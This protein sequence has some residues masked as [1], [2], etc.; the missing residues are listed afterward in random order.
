MLQLQLHAEVVVLLS[1]LLPANVV[2]ANFCEI[3]LAVNLFLALLQ[4]P[5]I[6]FKARFLLWQ[7]FCQNHSNVCDLEK[8]LQTLPTG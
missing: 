4:A 6:K 7:R 2:T 1:L 5:L 3:E 8:S